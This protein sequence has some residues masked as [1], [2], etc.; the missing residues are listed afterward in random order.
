M[1]LY[2]WCFVHFL[3]LS[4]PFLSEFFCL[5]PRSL[6]FTRSA[7]PAC[8][9]SSFAYIVLFFVRCDFCSYHGRQ[10]ISSRLCTVCLGLVACLFL[11]VSM[12][13]CICCLCVRSATNCIVLCLLLQTNKRI[14]LARFYAYVIHGML[15]CALC[16]CVCHVMF[17]RSLFLTSILSFISSRTLSFAAATVVVSSSSSPSLVSVLFLYMLSVPFCISF[18]SFCSVVRSAFF[19]R[20]PFFLCQSVVRFCVYVCIHLS[21]CAHMQVG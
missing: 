4:M 5:F 9:C 15:F 12:S 11:T 3:A 7:S 17:F 6:M 13:V 21:A 20:F 1:F 8:T 19:Q 16:V 14:L 10:R 18:T 2:P